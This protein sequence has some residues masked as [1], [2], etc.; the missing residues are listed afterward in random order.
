MLTDRPMTKADRELLA[1][2]RT[3]A[4][5]RELVD[6]AW[7]DDLPMTDEDDEPSY[8]DPDQ[9]DSLDAA[10][11]ADRANDLRRDK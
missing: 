10:D 9:A 11:A 1:A 4:L 6:A 2:M 8:T 5:D 7:F 3:R